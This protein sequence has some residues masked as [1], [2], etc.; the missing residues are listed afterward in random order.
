MFV[1]FAHIAHP[2]IDFVATRKGR[3][4]T[5]PLL[6]RFSLNETMVQSR[7]CLGLRVSGDLA[8]WLFVGHGAPLQSFPLI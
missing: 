1:V 4:Y 7:C 2:G 6:E 3:E 8:F 5:K